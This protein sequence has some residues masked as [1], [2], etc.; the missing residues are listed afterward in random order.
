M[1]T[2]FENQTYALTD[3]ELSM[4]DSLVEYLKLAT[5]E[6][7]H[8]T[9][10]SLSKMYGVSGPRIRKMIHYI[11]T[12][13][14]LLGLVAKSNGYYVTNELVDLLKYERSLSER[15]ASIEEVRKALASHINNI[16]YEVEWSAE[17]NLAE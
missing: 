1:I 6:E 17:K 3:R 13:N 9:A 2:N 10:S 11:R 16:L 8:V 12:N 7:N 15:I 4:I 14:L 5:G